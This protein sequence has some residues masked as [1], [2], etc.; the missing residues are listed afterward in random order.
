MLVLYDEES[1]IKAEALAEAKLRLLD[2]GSIWVHN[3]LDLKD[4]KINN[5]K[6]HSDMVEYFKDMVLKH[7]TGMKIIPHYL[8]KVIHLFQD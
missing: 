4:T 8:M 2:E 6:L 7:Q 5:K 3:Q 1:H